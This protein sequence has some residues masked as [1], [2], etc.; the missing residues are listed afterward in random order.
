MKYEFSYY[1]Q[2]NFDDIEN[3]I[4]NSYSWE[5]PIYGISRLEFCSG[6]HPY[7]TGIQRTMERGSGIFRQN[8]KIIAAAVNEVNAAGDAFFIFDSKERS[9]DKELIEHM[10]FF[11]QTGMSHKEQNGKSRYVNLRVPQ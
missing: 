6:L 8:G 9:Q 5:Y 7:F 10:I 11:A 4:L 1:T 3:M 2:D